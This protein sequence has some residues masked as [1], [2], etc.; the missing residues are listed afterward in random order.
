MQAK[1]MAK[2]DRI[3]LEYAV[4]HDR[5]FPTEA[6]KQLLQH[7]AFLENQ[8]ELMIQRANL[9]IIAGDRDWHTRTGETK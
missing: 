6:V 7:V 8:Q 4:E 5:E 9:A 2:Y 1:E 3:H